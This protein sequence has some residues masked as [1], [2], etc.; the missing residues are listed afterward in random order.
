MLA[1][2]ASSDAIA[3]L[4]HAVS[5]SNRG[6][7]Y[8]SSLGH[9]LGATG[10]KDLAGEIVAELKEISKQ[11]YVGAFELAL[12]YLGTDDDQEALR[13]LER[14]YEERDPHLP[15]L[16]VDPRLARLHADPRFATLLSRV[17]L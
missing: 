16:R 10:R 4:T 15:F 8:L 1:K 9:A 7:R 6:T 12:V 17:G 13:C 5:L 14:A 2:G 3:A 11:R